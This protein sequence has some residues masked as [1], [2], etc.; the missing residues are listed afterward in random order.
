MR[1]DGLLAYI[2]IG[3]N[4]DDPERQVRAAIDALKRLPRS[5]FAGASRLFRTAPWGKADQPAFVNAAAAVSTALSPR[6]LLDALLAIERARGRVR[7]GERWGP[8]VIDLD[9]LVYGDARIDEIGL[10]VPH[11]HLAERAFAL[12]PLVDLAPEL[13]IPGLGPVRALIEGIDATGCTALA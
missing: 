13:E 7:D 2:G 11:P 4:L 10:H 12:L 9:I 3:S 6:E 8:R 5:T 1:V